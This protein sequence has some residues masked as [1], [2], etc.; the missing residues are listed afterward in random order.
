MTRR[1]EGAHHWVYW[2]WGVNGLAVLCLLGLG[3]LY[4]NRQNA[5]A[6]NAVTAGTPTRGTVQQILPTSFFLPTLTPNPNYTPPPFESQADNLEG[7]VLIPCGSSQAHV[8]CW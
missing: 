6:S 4:L 8:Y 3:L 7:D 2:I 1:K 5:L